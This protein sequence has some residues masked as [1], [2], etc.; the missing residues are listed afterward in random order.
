MITKP[1][2]IG[3]YAK[4][5]AFNN[6]SRLVYGTSALGGVWGPV[7]ESES[8]DALL[9]ALENGIS[10]L[11]TAPSYANSELYVGKALQQWKGEK[12]FVSTK[13]GRLRGDDAFDVKLDYSP[14]AM[15]RSLSNSLETLGLEYIDLLFLHEPQLVPL[16]KIEDILDTL[17]GFKSEGL[18]KK[19]GV[20]GNPSEAFKP[21]IT[22]DNFDVVSGFLRMDACNLSAYNGEIQQYKKEGIAYYAASALHFSLLGNRFEQYKKEGIDGEWI[23]QTD[24]DNAIRVKT[25]ADRIHIPL[26]TL[27]QRYLFSIAEADRVVMGA[28]NMKQIQ[29]TIKDWKLG[30]LSEDIFNEITEIITV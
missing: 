1:T 27:A 26:A 21:F 15:K 7:D 18:V 24:L 2:Y 12:P 9:F 20:G 22:K 23:T 25:V 11:D 14:E 13:I 16:E 8:I 28:R 30:K 10:V 3:D 29:S 19:L 17:K 4:S 5:V 6:Q